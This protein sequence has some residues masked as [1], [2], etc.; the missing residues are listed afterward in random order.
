MHHHLKG[1]AQRRAGT[2][3]VLREWQR[4]QAVAGGV[5]ASANGNVSLGSILQG[6]PWVW[7]GDRFVATEQVAF[8]CPANAT[9]YLFAVPSDLVCFAAL[10]KRFGVR[11]RFGFTDFSGG[12]TFL[13]SGLLPTLCTTSYTRPAQL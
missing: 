3:P 8:R 5:V 4:A 7:V 6:K 1:I 12:G 13:A 9:P 10:L 2:P 11:P